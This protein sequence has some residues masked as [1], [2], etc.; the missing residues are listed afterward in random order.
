MKSYFNTFVLLFILIFSVGYAK[1]DFE[2]IDSQKNAF[3]HNNQGLVYVE[4]GN[5]FAAVKEFKM[6]IDLNP[7][8][9][10]TAVYY[11]NL[12]NVYYKLE[13]SRY[14]IQCFESAIALYPLN[15][16]YYKSLA[17]AY[18][19]QGTIKSKINKVQRSNNILDKV[20][21]GFLYLES[22]EKTRGILTLDSFCMAEPDL[23]IT[24]GVKYYIN[25]VRDGSYYND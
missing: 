5:Y 11:S 12:G 19:Q 17:K 14:A 24:N 4:Q 25:K 10:A 15:V 18:K 1:P 9:Q 16:E 2:V 22:G 7:G 8:T 20:L 3:F 13:F 21:L 6:A 23:L